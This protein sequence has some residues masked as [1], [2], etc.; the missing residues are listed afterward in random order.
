MFRYVGFVWN[1]SNPQGQETAALLSK[2]MQRTH[3]WR[4]ALE[5]PGLAVFC[6]GESASAS[7]AQVLTDSAGVVLGTV[8]QTAPDLAGRYRRASID[9]AACRRVQR[10]HGRELI[11]HYW[12]RYVAFIRDAETATTWIV[13][14]PTGDLDCMTTEH[15]GVQIFF[16]M[17]EDCPPLDHLSF[18]LN[19]DFLAAVI[20]VRQS[21]QSYQTGLREVSRVLSG[22]CLE[23]RLDGSVSRMFYWHPFDIIAGE[24]IDDAGRAASLLHDTTIA[25]VHAWASCYDRILNFLSGGLDSS[26]IAG[27]LKTVASKPLVT[28]FHTFYSAGSGSD[29]RHYARAVAELAGMPLLEYELDTD[30]NLQEIYSIPR[31]V[32]PVSTFIELGVLAKRRSI[33][34]QLGIGGI[35]DG[36]G[37]DQLFF[38]NGS[39]YACPDYI[40]DRGLRPGLFRTA[41]DAAYMEGNVVW[42]LLL[43]GLRDAFSRRPL[44]SLLDRSIASD[45]LT[46]DAR[47]RVA[48]QR[49]FVHPWFTSPR[50]VPPGKCWQVQG[51]VMPNGM[52]NSFADLAGPEEI[53]PLLS[54]PLLEL[55]LRTP[56]YVLASG[57]VDRALARRAFAAEVPRQILQRR[58]KGEV[59]LF[60]KV[61]YA[62]NRAFVREILLSGMLVSERILDR[63][64]IEHALNGAPD[65][66]EHASPTGLLLLASAEAW[67][68]VCRRPLECVAA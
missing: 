58:V 8:F 9:S 23:L 20:A 60:P 4:A 67:L 64:R 22:E 49:L 51:L 68:Q 57:G 32:E 2:T 42:S 30:V 7:T 14:D 15:R 33:C 31:T 50:R 28:N 52:S 21:W 1:A 54:Q 40:F 11:E 36:S 6:A 16:S 37:G 47:A 17:M 59:H 65:A 63:Q 53:H 41:L 13:R 3:E 12:G 46:A 5:L 10:T 39:Q 48:E 61:L 56:T 26:I 35:F 43:H 19:W 34:R 44:A 62:K 27:C 66:S 38:Q 45:M 18:S 29:E 24:R 25:C 55:C